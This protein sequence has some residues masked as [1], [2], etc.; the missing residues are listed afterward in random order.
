MAKRRGPGRVPAARRLA[1]L[2]AYT[3]CC[4]ALHG[5]LQQHY[6]S[7]CRSSWLSLFAVDPGP[8]C[9]LVR[10]GLSALQWSPVF[11][12]PATG[13]AAFPPSYPHVTAE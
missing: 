12:L 8:Y 10:K 2:C 11:A 7:T 1:Y 9:A 13:F 3:A 6:I 4:A 5:L